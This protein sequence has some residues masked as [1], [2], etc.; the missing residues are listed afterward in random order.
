MKWT[1][2]AHHP[3]HLVGE[4]VREYSTSGHNTCMLKSRL[5]FKIVFSI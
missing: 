3:E 5:L 4:E 1:T 2:T